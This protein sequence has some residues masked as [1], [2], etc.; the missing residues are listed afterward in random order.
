MIELAQKKEF[1]FYVLLM[2]SLILSRLPVV[3][4]FFRGI[5]TLIHESAHALITLLLGGRVKKIELF[6]DNSGVT[7]TQSMGK[8]GDFWVAFAGY[9]VSSVIGFFFFGFIHYQLQNIVIYVVVILSVLSLFLIKNGYGIFWLLVILSISIFTLY[10]K[11][12]FISFCVAVFIAFLSL[13]DSFIST[14]ILFRAVWNNSKQ[15]GDASLLAKISKIPAWFWASFFVIF[16]GY[17]TFQ[18]VWLFFLPLPF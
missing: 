12:P 8:R 15:A 5:N 13:S 7:L 2:L 16:S 14:F 10:V 17:V 4:K 3:G 9:P 18:T 11:D 6:A 1:I